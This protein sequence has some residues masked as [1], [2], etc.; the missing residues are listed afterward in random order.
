MHD[1]QRVG[2]IGR[3]VVR[4]REIASHHVLRPLQPFE[5][6]HSRGCRLGAARFDRARSK[7]RKEVPQIFARLFDPA[8]NCSRRVLR[9][10]SL[11]G[12]NEIGTDTPSQLFGLCIPERPVCIHGASG[13]VLRVKPGFS[14][15]LPHRLRNDGSTSLLDEG[16][17]TPLPEH[18]GW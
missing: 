12:P 10:L 6:D 13:D 9:R 18:I 2:K 3:P 5:A 1:P 7:A 15:V 14:D 8:E 4:P 11:I 17:L 16:D